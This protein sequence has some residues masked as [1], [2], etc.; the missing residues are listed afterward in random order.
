MEVITIQSFFENPDTGQ[1]RD[2][3]NPDRQTSDRIFLDFGLGHKSRLV[4]GQSHDF[5]QVHEEERE[6]EHTEVTC[7]VP[8]TFT[9]D[10]A[11]HGRQSGVIKGPTAAHEIENYNFTHCVLQSH[12]PFS[13]R[14]FGYG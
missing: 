7:N 14:N 2:R 1:N 4:Y 10:R 8:L 6:R 3:Q 11:R 5:V 13:E 12:D 9:P